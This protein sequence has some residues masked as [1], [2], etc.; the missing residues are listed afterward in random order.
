MF[1][2]EVV[3]KFVLPHSITKIRFIYID[4]LHIDP[5]N[6]MEWLIW[7]FRLEIKESYF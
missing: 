7:T 1:E 3:V 2:V 6:L 4:Q 5:T